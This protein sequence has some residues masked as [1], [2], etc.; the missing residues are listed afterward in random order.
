M[1]GSDDEMLSSADEGSGGEG[2]AAPVV[3]EKRKPPN[4]TKAERWAEV[5]DLGCFRVGP[6]D[7]ARWMGVK[8][9]RGLWCIPCGKIVLVSGTYANI[10]KHYTSPAHKSSWLLRTLTWRKC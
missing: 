6:A 4:K 9:D 5:K 10:R 1:A 3:G 8:K 2:A 7:E